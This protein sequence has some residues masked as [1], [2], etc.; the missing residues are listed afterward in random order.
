MVT[1]GVILKNV[2]SSLP[3]RLTNILKPMIVWTAFHAKE[4]EIVWLTDS[5]SSHDMTSGKGKFINLKNW[6]GGSVKFSDEGSAQI[7]GKGIIKI[8]GKNK[9]E[10]IIYVK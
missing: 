10:D 6:N 5:D 8:D 9:I 1:K 3:C 7:C 4:E 2:R